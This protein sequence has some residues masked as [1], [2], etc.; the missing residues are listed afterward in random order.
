MELGK[1]ELMREFA[2]IKE[3]VD[4]GHDLDPKFWRMLAKVKADE[5]LLGE[6]A[7]VIGAIDRRAFEGKVRLRINAGIGITLL[8]L[9]AALAMAPL[10]FFPATKDILGM[11]LVFSSMFMMT[12]LH[13][14]AH[15]AV[16]R[17]FGIR[18]THMFPDGPVKIEPSLKTDYATY[19]AVPPSKRVLFHL[20]GPLT[21]SLV[22]P[23]IFFFASLLLDVPAYVR[24]VLAAMLAMNIASEFTPIVLT[25]HLKKS[26]YLGMDFRKTD[27]VRALRERRL[28]R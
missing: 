13:D 12:L 24:Y 8:L 26:M 25:E 6:F 21:T 19:L 1:E 15:Y 10:L 28:T 22:V 18:F 4:V 17:L 11:R 27:L 20:S 5:E 2:R 3:E 9:W 23:S 7:S 14:P 16:G